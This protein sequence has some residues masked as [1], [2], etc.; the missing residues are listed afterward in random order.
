MANGPSVTSQGAVW[1]WKPLASTAF[2]VFALQQGAWETAYGRWILAGLVFSWVGDILLIPEDKTA[3]LWGLVSFLLAHV[4][5]GLGFYS[6]GTDLRWMVAAVPVLLILLVVIGRWLL[7][8]V[9]LQGPKMRLPVL[10]Y[11]GAVSAMVVLASGAAGGS[12]DWR[13][14]L[15]GAIFYLSDISVARDRFVAPGWINKAWG[16]PLYYV[17]QFIL[18]ATI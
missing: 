14:L 8:H 6:R 2:V 15:G 18:A 5:Y 17:A 4:A 11:M 10:V 3:F 12:G 13:I 1:I 16:L 7:P 9:R